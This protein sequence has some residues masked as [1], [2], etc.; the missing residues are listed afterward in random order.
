MFLLLGRIGPPGNT[1]L[2]GEK[3]IG[4]ICK[5]TLNSETRRKR[6]CRGTWNKWCKRR[7]WRKRR[8]W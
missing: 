5:F 7:Y 1:G 2:T 3:G 6:R 4:K 8:K